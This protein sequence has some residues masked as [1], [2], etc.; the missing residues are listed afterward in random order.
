MKIEQFARPHAITQD[1]VLRL[2]FLIPL[3]V[4]MEVTGLSRHQVR[5]AVAAGSLRVWSLNGSRK[6]KYYREDVMRLIGCTDRQI[7]PHS[8]GSAVPTGVPST[9]GGR[10]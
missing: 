9:L 10:P 3:S 2:P 4:V 7:R 8:P 1:F 6:G 5:S